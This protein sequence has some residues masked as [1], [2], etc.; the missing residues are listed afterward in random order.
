MKL[1]YNY[2]NKFLFYF[3]QHYL[4]KGKFVLNYI[5]EYLLKFL[6]EHI[7]KLIPWQ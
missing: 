1:T 4:K 6:M 2:Y 7:F 3:G 5:I